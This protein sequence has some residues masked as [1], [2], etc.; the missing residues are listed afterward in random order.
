MRLLNAFWNIFVALKE[1][2]NGSEGFAGRSVN[3]WLGTSAPS[4]WHLARWQGPYEGRHQGAEIG[5]VSARAIALE[6][7]C[8]CAYSQ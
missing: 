7:A 5:T 3:Q 6:P 4:S 2:W 8:H 1:A